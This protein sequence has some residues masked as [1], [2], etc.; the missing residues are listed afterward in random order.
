[1]FPCHGVS[2]FRA[3]WVDYYLTRLGQIRLH[4]KQTHDKV[5]I[6]MIDTG[7]NQHHPEMAKHIENGSIT[8][9]KGFPKELNP[10]EDKCGHGTHG[11]SVLLKTAPNAE[12]LVARVFDDDGK[13]SYRNMYQDIVEVMLTFLIDLLTLRQSIGL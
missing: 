4:L 13:M 3:K 1:M 7:I 6:A 11:A 10:L 9:W 12:L 2:K 5:G 8:L